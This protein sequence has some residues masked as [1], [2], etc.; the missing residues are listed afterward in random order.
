MMIRRA[1]E[2]DTDGED[3]PG[4]DVGDEAREAVRQLNYEA[5][6]ERRKRARLAAKVKTHYEIEQRDRKYEWANKAQ[7][8][9][10]GS[11]SDRQLGLVI[12]L[13]ANGDVAMK[14]GKRQAGAVIDQ[15]M[16]KGAT[17]NWSRVRQWE[18]NSG[19]K[20]D[21]RRRKPAIAAERNE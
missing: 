19:V 12:A 9:G 2:G 4:L 20:L 5:E 8:I 7:S 21:M 11:I 17:P 6:V 14:W 13:G 18:R 1:E 15:Y 16:R 10:R 3:G